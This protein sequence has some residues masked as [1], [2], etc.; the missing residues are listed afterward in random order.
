MRLFGT[1]FLLCASLLS[2]S[3]SAADRDSLLS[4]NAQRKSGAEGSLINSGAKPAAGS[5]TAMPS[6]SSP[7]VKPKSAEPVDEESG[8]PQPYVASVDSFGSGRLTEL[9]LKETLGSDL[10]A[11]LIKGM[12]GEPDALDLEHKLA[13][14]VKNKFGFALA[15]WSIVQYFEPG[16][17]AIHITLD[18]VERNDAAE[19]MPFHPAPTAELK[20][21]DGLIKQWIE[22]EDT[23]LEMVD[24][25]QLEPEADDCVAYHCPFGHKNP[26]LKKYE[27]IFVDGVKKNQKE[28]LEILARDK[29]GEHR[30]AAAYLLAYLKDGKKVVSAMVERIKDPDPMVRNNVLRVLGDMAEF[31]P[32][33]VIPAG[34]VLEA[35]NFPRVSDRSKAVYVAYLLALNSQQVREQILKTSV[36]ELLTFLASKQPDHREIAHGILRKVS[37]KEFPNTDIT[38]WTAWYGKVAKDKAITRK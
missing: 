15:E 19:R 9:A 5:V 12:K 25:G 28:L 20:D 17:F 27:K 33:F 36:P 38:S 1:C 22:Y 13:E 4:G 8:M 21:P 26:K 32:E 30:A 2:F 23:A 7:A 35:L 14:K 3:S 24:N 16:D 18:V 6:G 31:H 37:G 29:R 10:E 11:W 34:P